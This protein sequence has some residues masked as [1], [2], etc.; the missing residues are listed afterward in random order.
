MD[1][2]IQV[3]WNGKTIDVRSGI[4]LQEFFAEYSDP[5]AAL[6]VAGKVDNRIRELTWP[7]ES[8]CAVEPIDLTTK[9]GERIYTRSLVFVFIRACREIFPDCMVTVEHSF[10]GGLYCEVHGDFTLTSR[11]VRRIEKQ[12]A[13]I[14]E[15][16]DPFV[17]IEVS[18]DEANKIYEDMKFP[19]K[20]EIIRHR[21]EDIVSMYRCGWMSDYLYGYMVPS[22]GYLKQFG[23]K[24]YH[25]GVI[26][27]YPSSQNSG[28]IREFHD[29]PK[30]FSVF[31]Q[32]EKWCTA[33]G[34][35]N[36]A[37][38]NDCIEEGRARELILVS[39]AYQEKQ[40]AMIADEI[41]RRKDSVHLILIAGPS[42]SGKTTFAQRIRI[43]LMVNGLDPVPISMD[44]YFLNRDQ[45]PVDENGEQDLESIDIIDLELFN[46]QMTRL[47]QGQEVE[48]P[49]FN[50]LTGKREYIGQV[51][52]LSED[53]PIIVEGIHG[54]NEKLTEMIPSENKYKIY[55]SA[56]T[57]LNVDDH[58]RIPT[59]DARL[60]RR[61]VRD[62]SYR[63]TSVEETLKLWPLVRRGEERNIFPFQESADVMFNSALLYELAVL[64]HHILPL[65]EAVSEDHEYYPEVNRLKKFMK[66]FIDLD[67]HDIPNNS[68]L[69]EFI[70]GSCFE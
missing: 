46:E 62:Y 23:L 1:Q 49:Y 29:N 2:I 45:V 6:I 51:I 16:N 65:L 47:I 21:P 24:F 27:Q 7:L 42:S 63:G 55:I 19:D 53:Q 9:D 35:R 20:A 15:K 66:Y 52:K 43:Q 8:D 69:R 64:K 3:N 38:L 10:G 5:E 33:M 40:I 32:A 50:F 39:E 41:T 34:I 28:Q 58:N 14:I 57:Q 17:R 44:N 12:M 61:M 68:I 18:K 13:A 59:T 4:T 70:G 36:I 56:L 30:L 54:L 37:D 26:I 22:T 60:I 67:S 31:R 48:T 11:Q 25:P